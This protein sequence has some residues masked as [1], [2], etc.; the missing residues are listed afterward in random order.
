VD[1]DV[2]ETD[3]VDFAQISLAELPTFSN[4][5]LQRSLRRVQEHADH[6]QDAFA[7]FNSAL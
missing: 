2:Y 6:P 5:V 7:G 4:S 1:N 3:L